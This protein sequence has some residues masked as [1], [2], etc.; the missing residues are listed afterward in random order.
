MPPASSGDFIRLLLPWM[1]LGAVAAT[2]LIAA[3]SFFLA[4]RK[5]RI[6]LGALL[7]GEILAVLGGHFSHRYPVSALTVGWLVDSPALTQLGKAHEESHVQ[8]VT[9]KETR[10]EIAETRARIEQTKTRLR[11]VESEVI[12]L[13]IKRELVQNETSQR[14]RELLQIERE[15]REMTES[16]KRTP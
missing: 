4:D 13:K 15:V 6:A 3:F 11:E 2:A 10:A 7:A 1:A 16:V 8:Y 9:L 12:G 5:V 14:I